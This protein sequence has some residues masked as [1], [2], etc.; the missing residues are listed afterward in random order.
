MLY[1]YNASYARA[2]L[3]YEMSDVDQTYRELAGLA[4]KWN[5]TSNGVTFDA[6]NFQLDYIVSDFIID[7]MIDAEAYT[8]ECKEG[9][10]TI[11]ENNMNFTLITDDTPPGAGDFERSI[12]INVTV[13]PSNLENS[14][15]FNYTYDENGKKSA[16]VKFCMRFSLYTNGATPIEV[17]YLETIVGFTADLSSGFTIDGIA[18]EPKEVEEVTAT[19]KYSVDAYKCNK[20]DDTLSS[21]ALSLAMT[22]GEV[23]RVCVT[24]NQDAREQGLYMNAIE[25]F[26]FERDY[27]GP[28]GLIT[29]IAIENKQ[30][31]SNYMTALFCTPGSLICAF[32]TV[33]MADFFISPGLTYG[34]GTAIL[35]FG[36]SPTKWQRRN[37]EKQSPY[38]S[39]Q[40]DDGEDTKSSFELDFDLIQGEKFNGILKT[41][42]GKD[43]NA[44][45]SFVAIA[46]VIAL[47]LLLL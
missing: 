8:T 46:T 16:E 40:E 32:E 42:S 18:V 3:E 14:V 37:E 10:Q 33:L 21:T 24:P 30:E 11:P 7:S 28:I 26:T 5:L 47:N 20:F 41:T 2:S 31:A 29:Q 4:Q 25:D 1:T 38:R 23:I 6:L 22:Q 39:L 13:N 44:P 34:S 17:N 15:V 45:S 19:Q 36:D 27:G 9:G 43:S 12:S 35:Q